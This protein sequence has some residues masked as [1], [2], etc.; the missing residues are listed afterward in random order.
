[1]RSSS[2]KTGLFLM[3]L[4]LA[5]LFFS[6]ACAVCVQLFVKSHKI[7]EESDALNHSILWAQNVAETFYGTDGDIDEMLALLPGSQIGDNGTSITIPYDDAC[8]LTAS[9]SEEGSLITCDIVV[10]VLSAEEEIY[11]LSVTKYIR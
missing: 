5:V 1:M 3:E 8:V 9:L 7:S 11:Q 4:I 6:V 2:S 10:K